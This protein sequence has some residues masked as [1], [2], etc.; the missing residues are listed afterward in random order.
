MNT[1]SPTEELLA[2]SISPTNVSRE[3]VREWVTLTREQTARANR[4][5]MYAAVLGFLV[6]ASAI[7]TSLLYQE[8]RIR[9]LVAIEPSK[10]L[11]QLNEITQ[12]LSQSAPAEYFVRQI[13]RAKLRGFQSS[14]SKTR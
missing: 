5:R 6:A 8:E 2:G 7:W 13:N 1:A 10:S 3:E 14:A 11:V 9:Q 4:R 12:E